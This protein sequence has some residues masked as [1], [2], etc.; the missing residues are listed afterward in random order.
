MHRFRTDSISSYVY[1]VETETTS[2]ERRLFTNPSIVVASYWPLEQFTQHRGNLFT[3][4]HHNPATK[5]SVMVVQ[6]L[7]KSSGHETG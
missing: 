7:L 1:I 6:Y 3:P 4:T 2:K 5:S